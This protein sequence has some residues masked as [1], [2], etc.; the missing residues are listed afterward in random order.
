MSQNAAVFHR[1]ILEQSSLGEKLQFKCN[2]QTFPTVT[3]QACGKSL[4]SCSRNDNNVSH[5]AF[6]G[7]RTQS[8]FS[9]QS[10]HSYV[11]VTRSVVWKN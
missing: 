2:T 10:V 9:Q 4:Y 11:V 6:I 7:V 3:V 1:S 5:P 8:G